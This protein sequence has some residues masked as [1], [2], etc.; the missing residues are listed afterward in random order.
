VG[1]EKSTGVTA[2]ARAYIFIRDTITAGTFPVGHPL[3][4]EEV[5][6]TAGVSRTPVRE[7]L[8][9][10]D[11][12]GLVEFLPNREARV[13]GWTEHELNE[14]FDLRVIFESYGARLA[15]LNITADQL[16][17]LGTLCNEMDA[18]VARDRHIRYQRLTGLNNRFHRGVFEANGNRR[19]M[20]ISASVV[21]RSLVTLTFHLYNPDQLERSCSGHRELVDAVEW[22]CSKFSHPVPGTIPK[23][24]RFPPQ[25]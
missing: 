5:A 6:E 18:E 3:R 7:V 23:P 22:R 12:E 21:Q 13:A 14:I 17:C 16:N 1:Q 20:A 19:L 4:E 2:C 24:R 8:R 25:P 9:R 15:A 11:A 10:L